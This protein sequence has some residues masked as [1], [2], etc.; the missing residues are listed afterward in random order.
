MGA[1]VDCLI[2]QCQWP[3]VLEWA[4]RWIALGH[5]PEPAYR[6]LML[7]NAERGDRAR[8][9][10]VYQRCREL[11][12]EELGAQPSEQTRQLFERLSRGERVLPRHG[13]EAQQSAT[14]S[15]TV[16]DQRPA[17]GVPPF[18]GLQRFDEADAERFFGREVITAR[19]LERLRVEPFLAVI[20]ASGSG[21]SSIVR[22]GV[23]ATLRHQVD[24]DCAWVI[25]VL[26]P[27]MHPL[28]A[29]AG[30]LARDARSTTVT[31]NLLSDLAADPRSLNLFLQDNPLAGQRALLVVD[32]FE[33]LFTLCHDPYEREAF[34]DNLLGACDV[35][36]STTVLIALRADFYAHCADY[37]DL[38]QALADHQE[39]VGPMDPD[40]MRRAIELPA[41]RG[42]WSL[43]PGLVDLLLRDAGEEPCALP[44]LSHPPLETWQRR[45]AR[46]LL[47]HGY[48]A[49]RDAPSA[50]AAR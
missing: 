4:E 11:L 42:D 2:E 50:N 8:I 7:A 24:A 25:R 18:Q 49:H 26:T 29:L 44:L 10:N 34:V 16:E 6:A 17:P 21:K 13:V 12:F 22:A 27:T 30:A 35:G 20:G 3:S 33:E 40:D 46:S 14:G 32:Q 48:H 23:V 37:P 47:L 1:L 31:A 41:A 9:A 15:A 45:R 28:E 19:V 5:V 38:R 39:Y 43:Q 36:A